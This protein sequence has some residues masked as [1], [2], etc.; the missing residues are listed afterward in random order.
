MQPCNGYGI[1]KS[2]DGGANFSLSLGGLTE[3]VWSDI[4]VTSAGILI[5]AIS[6]SFPK[7]EST[8]KFPGIYKSSDGDKL[9][10]YYSIKF[11][12]IAFANCVWSFQ[13]LIRILFYSFTFTGQVNNQTQREEIKFYKINLTNDSFEDRS[14]NL[15]DLGGEGFIN[16]QGSYNMVVAVKPDNENFVMIGATSLFRSTNGFA[17]KPSNAKK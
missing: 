12:A 16:T 9:D 17:T 5:G 7:L 4:A 6:S 13:R 2:T 11:S 10:K 14:A 3:H 8:E 1:F 15:P